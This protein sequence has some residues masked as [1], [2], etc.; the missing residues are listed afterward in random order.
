M[1]VMEEGPKPTGVADV[2][3]NITGCLIPWGAD[4]EPVLLNMIGSSSLYLPVFS[5]KDKLDSCLST[6]GVSYVRIK[7]VT[8]GPEFMSYIPKEIEVVC[9]PWY[10]ETGRVRFRQIRR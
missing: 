2:K 9:D 4:N 6:A 8:N 5:S 7:V 10:T 1:D 3:L